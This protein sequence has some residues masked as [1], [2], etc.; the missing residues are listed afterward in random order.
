MEQKEI[1]VYSRCKLYVGAEKCA[2]IKR[3][4]SITWNVTVKN[5]LKELS[6]TSVC[7]ADGHVP[8]PRTSRDSASLKDMCAF[9][10]QLLVQNARV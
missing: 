10:N 2:M 4:T 8:W 6:H 9:R 7:Y 3:I 1:L 5:Y